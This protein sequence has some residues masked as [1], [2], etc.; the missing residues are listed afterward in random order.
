[1]QLFDNNLSS[2]G[3]KIIIDQYLGPFMATF[4]GGNC[5]VL[6]DNAPTHCTDLIYEALNDNNSDWTKLPPYSPDINIIELVWAE[7]KRFLRKKLL[8]NN[9]E[10]ANRVKLFFDTELTVE[11][12]RN[13]I[14]R[15]QEVM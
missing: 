3:Y 13:Y 7:L 12:C 4:N 15:V 11:K 1:M 5:R 14:S 6:Q 9:Q 2:E 8:K 10:I